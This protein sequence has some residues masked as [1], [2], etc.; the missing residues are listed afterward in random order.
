MFPGLLRS[1]VSIVF[2]GPAH[3][4]LQKL[5][6]LLIWLSKRTA[7]QVKERQLVKSPLYITTRLAQI[8]RS[9]WV[10]QVCN[11]LE[12]TAKLVQQRQTGRVERSL[13]VPT[14]VAYVKTL[15]VALRSI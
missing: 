10:Q 7:E 6:R 9:N 13:H 2:V 15:Q 8:Q 4:A 3:M 1:T 5:S 12:R 11:V 14:L